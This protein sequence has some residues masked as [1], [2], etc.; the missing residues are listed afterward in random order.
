MNNKQYVFMRDIITKYHPR[1]SSCPEYQKFGLEMAEVLNVEKLFEECLAEVGGYNR[2]D[3]AGR[4]FDDIHNSDSK[5]CTVIG[6]DK[7]THKHFR[8]EIGSVETKIGSLRIAIFN[9]YNDCIDFAY[10]PKQY[11]PSVTSKC[12]GKNSHKRRI[13]ITWSPDRDHYNKFE[14]FRV[15]NFADL[16]TCMK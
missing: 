8:A 12:Y 11:V 10:I 7:Y 9:P 1:F 2:I 6:Y 13:D 14:R 15:S 3:E 16:A 5:T 4:D